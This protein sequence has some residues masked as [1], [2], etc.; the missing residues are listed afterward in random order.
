MGPGCWRSLRGGFGFLQA[1]F[2]DFHVGKFIGI[3]DLTAFQAL[4]KLT[5][6][7]ARKDAHTG[8][9]TGFHDSIC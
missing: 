5:L 2:F 6:F 1:A 8:M 9:F 7:I 3:E 4:D